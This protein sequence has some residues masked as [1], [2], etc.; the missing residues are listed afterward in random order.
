MRLPSLDGITIVR[1]LERTGFV[2]ARRRG[3]HQMLRHPDG[4]HTVVPVH[5]G[6]GIGP[7]LL[8]KILRDVGMS[9][10]EFAGLLRG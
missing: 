9:R 8:S 10:E 7:G 3:S 4:R 2:V 1:A 6:G 5:A